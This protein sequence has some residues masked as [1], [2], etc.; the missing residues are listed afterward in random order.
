MRAQFGSRSDHDLEDAL[1]VVDF[2]MQFMPAQHLGVV[3]HRFLGV[4][5]D[6]GDVIDQVEA[7]DR[8]RFDFANAIV[9]EV[10]T[11]KVLSSEHT[12]HDKLD[13]VLTNKVIGIVIFQLFFC[14]HYH[15][16]IYS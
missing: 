8:R 9:K 4:G 15:R 3:L 11:R 10:E 2:A 16:L 1:L 12:S 5:A 7:E 13:S 14:N 6:I